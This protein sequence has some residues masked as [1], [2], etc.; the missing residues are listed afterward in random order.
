MQIGAIFHI[1]GVWRCLQ[2]RKPLMLDSKCLA[3][4]LQARRGR[5]RRPKGTL[6]FEDWGGVFTAF[7]WSCGGTQ[8]GQNPTQPDDPWIQGSADIP[9]TDDFNRVLGQLLKIC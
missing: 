3:G 5:Q 6:H 8:G 9:I 7:L 2:A 1:F 4:S